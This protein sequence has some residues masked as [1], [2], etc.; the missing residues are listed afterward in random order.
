MLA[1][2]LRHHEAGRLIEAEQIYRQILAINARQADSLHL[3]G[4]IEYQA[5]H[6]ETAVKMIRKAMAINKNEATYHSNLG[7]VLQAQGKLDEAASCYKRA[8]ALKPNYPEALG[9]LGAALQI[10]GKLDEA[11]ACYERALLLKPDSVEAHG[12]LGAALQLQGK[13]DE[14]VA[15]QERALALKP[16][17]AEAWFNLGNTRKKQGNLDEAIACFQRGLAIKPNSADG[18]Y[19]LGNTLQDAGKLDEAVACYR[20]ALTLKPEFAEAHS[21]L[22]NTLN[23]Q[24]RL[25]EAIA[26]HKCAVALKPELPDSHYN[27]GN[28]LQAD[29]RLDEAV[30]CYERSLAL[31]PDFAK[32]HH[33]L[34][35]ARWASG[36]L[37]EALVLY[38]RA[39]AFQPDFA[40]ARFGESLAQLY[41][42]DFASGWRKY[43]WR[44]QTKEHDTRM[45]SY[46]QP[47]WT[48]E[49]LASGQLL[50]WREQGVGDEIMFA[51]LIPD[52]IRTGNR[53]VLD[54]D[55]RLK[56]LFARSF[57]N[58]DVVSTGDPSHDFELDFAAHLPCGSLPSLFRVT[59]A[60]FA[61]TT[62][63]YVIADPVARDCFKNQYSD[64]RRLV[65]LAW[66]TKNKKTG[67][68]R[69]I[70]LSLF[71]SLFARP[72]I[73]LV[74][75]QYGNHD[76]L[77]AQA[78][79]A[80]APIFVDRSV[81]QFSDID[82]F[83]AQI[84]AMDMVITIDNS[85]A[86]LAAALGVPTWVLLPFAP[87]WRWLHAR[88]DSPWYPTMRLF[89]QPRIGDWQSVIQKVQSCL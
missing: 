71:A 76:A 85:T 20:R 78:A 31:K 39:L 23:A 89:R 43:E 47:L 80:G 66:Y 56:T 24:G 42:G 59:D 77:E 46:P 68:N 27:L 32:A 79:L 65:G 52:V 73:R 16:D 54:C 84:A 48:G 88:E 14:A 33:N 10:L 45:R 19:N 57:P 55:A 62:S 2:A 36:N 25:D 17:C 60:A 50:I 18:C 82:R 83:A 38:R 30:A 21:N 64:G 49:K 51:G 7:I 69:S 29:N 35:C 22:G 34:G 61:A 40:Q 53:C 63:P 86:H 28:A 11:V 1:N 9:N 26:H 8:L 37:D 15:C 70:D 58:I 5:G 13:L 41:L 12:N 4:M 75:L 74:S 72:D 67:R 81:N 6:R 3:L 87:D 44:W